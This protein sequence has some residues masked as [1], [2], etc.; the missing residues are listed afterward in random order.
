MQ[1]G[2]FLASCNLLHLHV[3]LL[4]T[5]SKSKLPQEPGS[6]VPHILF[7]GLWIHLYL[8]IVLQICLYIYISGHGITWQGIK[9]RLQEASN[10]HGICLLCINI[11]V[12]NQLKNRHKSSLYYTILKSCESQ[13]STIHQ[14]W[15]YGWDFQNDISSET[16]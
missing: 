10:L 4:C 15:K 16:Y 9:F 1:R 2:S 7:F 12:K 13:P 11:F 14:T 5:K 3:Q 6:Q 8:W